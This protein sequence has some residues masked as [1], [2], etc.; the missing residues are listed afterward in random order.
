MNFI[1]LFFLWL[2]TMY[3]FHCRWC[4]TIEN[5]ENSGY[6]K[7]WILYYVCLCVCFFPVFLLS[8]F[9]LL[10]WAVF[11]I[12]HTCHHRAHQPDG[13]DVMNMGVVFLFVGNLTLW[14][15]SQTDYLPLIRIHFLAWSK[16]AGST[17]LLKLQL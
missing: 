2:G 4:D 10:P 17:F 6:V 5:I 9:N 11:P 15:A 3:I 13:N 7:V 1:L 8:S 14:R 12:N 16:S